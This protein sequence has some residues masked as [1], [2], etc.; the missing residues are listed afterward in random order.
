MEYYSI[1]DQA[2][3]LLAADKLDLFIVREVVL[4]LLL[5]ILITC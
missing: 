3:P 5:C 1:P 4:Q 2:Y